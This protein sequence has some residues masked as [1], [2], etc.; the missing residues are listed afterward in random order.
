MAREIKLII[1]LSLNY[2]KQKCTYIT[3]IA[4]SQFKGDNMDNIYIF[5]ICIV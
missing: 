4:D 2:R 3:H 5:L 1:S